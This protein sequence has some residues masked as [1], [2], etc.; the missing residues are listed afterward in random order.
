MRSVL[1]YVLL[2]LAPATLLA[3]GG[4]AGLVTDRMSG[5]PV[6]GVTVRV[7]GTR[8]GAITGKD[9]RFRLVPVPK[10]TLVLRATRVGYRPESITVVVD[11]NDVKDVVFTM[12][13]SQIQGRDVVVSANKRVQAVQDVPISVA[14]MKADDLNQRAIT[15]LDDALAYVSGVTVTRDQVNIRGSSGFALGVGSRTAVVMDGFPLLSGDNG[16]VKFDVLPVADIERVEIVKGAGSALY[17][18]GALGGVV[19]IITKTPTEKA[20]LSARL[21]S[22]VWTL[23]RFDQWR[24]RETLPLQTGA[25][26]RYAQRFGQVSVSASGGLRTDESYRDFDASIRGFGFAKVGW[27]VNDRRTLT[28]QALYAVDDREN[29]VFWRSFER[30]TLTAADQDPSE[31][32]YSGKLAAGIEWAE[33]LSGATSLVVRPSLFRTNYFNSIGGMQQDSNTSVAWTYGVE[34]QTTSRLSDAVVLTAGLNARINDVVSDVYGNQVQTLFSAYGQAEWTARPGMIVT[35]GARVDRE[36]TITVDP[37]L[38]ISPKLGLSWSVSDAT[39]LRASL[40]RGF[41]APTIAERYATIQYSAIRVVPAERLLPEFS[42][43]AEL[44][45]NHRVSGAPFPMEVDMAVFDNEL[46][47]MIEPAFLPSGVVQFQ[48]ITRARVLGAEITVRAMLA[49]WAGVETGLT[50]M[51]PKDLVVEQTLK[52][53]NNVIWYSRGSLR[54]FDGVELQIEHRFL[55]RTER[56]DALA[57]VP[58]YDVRVPIHIVDARLLWSVASMTRVMLQA[59]NVMDYYYTSI[60]ANLGPTRSV[61]MQVE[62]AL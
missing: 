32:L 6:A 19:S 54:P 34:A 12:I 62:W 52:Y 17:G 38:V 37:N 5:E 59:R 30:A 41:R 42:W 50:L 25:D 48:N 11:R 47:D 3:E 27:G 55:N 33:I 49:S 61:Q 39:S 1:V 21:Y 58:D 18:T 51:D 60:M 46:F 4:I 35:A 24:Y 44:G 23:P 43:S 53:R 29:Y 20:D 16:D 57:I 31:R 40:G 22:G 2:F 8:L 7:D 45:V 13:E 36:E 56:I 15:R 28:A 26:V 14:V 9:G 10:G